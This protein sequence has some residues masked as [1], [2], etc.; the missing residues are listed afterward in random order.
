[1]FVTLILFTVSRYRYL[2]T[3]WI[4][5]FFP[6][7][8]LPTLLLHVRSR[9][10]SVLIAFC[11]LPFVLICFAIRSVVRLFDCLGCSLFVADALLLRLFCVVTRSA[12]FVVCVGST[13]VDCGCC[14]CCSAFPVAFLILFH[15]DAV[16]QFY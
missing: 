5:S 10:C 7:P 12:F 14:F 13:V 16:L 8:S 15:C 2:A 4:C 3:C 6:S 11:S 9:F 1:M